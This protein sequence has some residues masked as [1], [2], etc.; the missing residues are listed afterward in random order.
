MVILVATQRHTE[1]RK[2]QYEEMTLD[3]RETDK[4]L[5]YQPTSTHDAS[6]MPTH[7]DP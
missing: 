7:R 1:T 3:F 2:H 6:A 5:S 4:R